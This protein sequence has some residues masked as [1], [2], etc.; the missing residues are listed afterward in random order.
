MALQ[1]NSFKPKAHLEEW[2]I[3]RVGEGTR[4]LV[5]HVSGHPRLRDG[6]RI[7]SSALVA[8]AGDG[9]WAETMNTVYSLGTRGEG[10]LPEEWAEHLD[11]FLREEW[12]TARVSEQ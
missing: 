10:P 11:F 5:G 6:A 1:P 8:L 3:I 4:H 9:S 12:R 7:V 2:R